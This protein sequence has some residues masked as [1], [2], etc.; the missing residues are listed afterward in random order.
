MM[1]HGNT[2]NPRPPT[3]LWFDTFGGIAVSSLLICIISGI[4]LAI[5]YDVSKAYLSIS[6]F[7]L[8]N[9]GAVIAR[10]M[11]YWSAQF[12]LVFSILHLWDHLRISSEKY[13]QASIWFRLILSLFVIM[14]AML[15]GFILKADADSSQALLIFRSLFEEIPLAGHPKL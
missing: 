13:T 5:P 9:P 3:K 10:N 15:S 1:V 6:Q 4:I 7:I 2:Y 12:F 8:S 11:H 14:F